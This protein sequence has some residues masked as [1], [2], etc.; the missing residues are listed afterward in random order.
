MNTYFPS[1]LANKRTHPR[2]R[3]RET[4]RARTARSLSSGDIFFVR[5]EDPRG[6]ITVY[7]ARRLS[8]SNGGHIPRAPMDAKRVARACAMTK[9]F[10]ALSA[11]ILFISCDIDYIRAF[12]RLMQFWLSKHHWSFSFQC[13][14]IYR[15]FSVLRKYWETLFFWYMYM[16]CKTN[17]SLY[18]QKL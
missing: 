3:R 16:L 17:C 7:R 5:S 14:L 9:H 6:V 8:S 10:S 4:K 12:R 2:C 11:Y 15:D 1:I 18:I 13:H